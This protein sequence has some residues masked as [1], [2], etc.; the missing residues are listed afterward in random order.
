MDQMSE[1]TV[2]AGVVCED[3]VDTP[4][5]CEPLANCR[6]MVCPDGYIPAGTGLQCAGGTCDEAVDL[7]TCCKEEPCCK[8]HPDGCDQVKSLFDIPNT[9]VLLLGWE[10]CPCTGIARKRFQGMDLCFEEVTYPDP[11][12][13]K[14]G[15]LMCNMERIIT[16]SSSCVRAKGQMPNGI[17]RR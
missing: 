16:P 4:T 11:M 12:D 15:Y 2:C 10:G 7:D 3:P 8:D 6:S 9:R 17:L 13:P 14:M 5:C 1:D